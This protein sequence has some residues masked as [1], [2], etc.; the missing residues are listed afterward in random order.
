MEVDTTRWHNIPRSIEGA[1]DATGSVL[2]P[3]PRNQVKTWNP[4]RR[5]WCLRC[6]QDN[7]TACRW[8]ILAAFPSLSLANT[9]RISKLV[10][11]AVVSSAW[12]ED[13]FNTFLGHGVMWA[14]PWW[15]LCSQFQGFVVLSCLQA[16]E[17]RDGKLLPLKARKFPFFLV[18]PIFNPFSIN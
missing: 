7:S 4:R 13:K 11:F 12:H 3:W 5:S 16:S 18:F 15:R 6:L 14:D 17:I 2:G 1:V 9:G 10:V 8:Q